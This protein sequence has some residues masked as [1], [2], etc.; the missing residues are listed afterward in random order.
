LPPYA[1]GDAWRAAPPAPRDRLWLHLL[2]FALTFLTTTVM[3]RFHYQGFLL[4]FVPRELLFVTPRQL[5]L[6]GLWYSVPLLAILT[7]HEMGHYLACRLYGV[8]A[9]MPFFLPLPPPVGLSGTLGAFIRIRSL[10][11]TKPVLFDMAAAGPIAG[12][13]VA[14]PA[15]I[16]GL[17]MSRVVPL[18]ADFVGLELGEPLLFKGISYLFFGAVPTGYSV[19]LHPMAMAAWFGLLVTA[20]NLMPVGQLDGGHISYAVFGRH[21]SRITL[22]ALAGIVILAVFFSYSWVVWAILLVVLLRVF[23]WEHPPTWDDEVPLDRGRLIVAGLTLLIF[24]ACF[25]PTPIQPY[26]LVRPR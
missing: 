4:D 8:N 13:V 11:R 7:A 18:P 12:F 14:V 3:G 21:S 15:M 6:G 19:N 5:W 10:I 25:T 17:S 9:S 2:L 26:E 1:A 23:G 16:W 24:V 22:G 20:M